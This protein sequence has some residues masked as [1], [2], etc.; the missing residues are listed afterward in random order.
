VA[1]FVSQN[2]GA[3]ADISVRAAAASPGAEVVSPQAAAKRALARM[4]GAAAWRL[5][6]SPM[7][8]GDRRRV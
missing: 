5:I 7:R 3:L 4:A 8:A 2:F 6:R 1:A